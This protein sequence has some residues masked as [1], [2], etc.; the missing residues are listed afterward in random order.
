MEHTK[1]AA[2]IGKVDAEGEAAGE[3]GNA[4]G[5]DAD[6]IVLAFGADAA[7]EIGAVEFTEELGQVGGVVL[8]VAVE[9]GDEGGF[10]GIESGEEGGALAAVDL[11]AD[12]PDVGELG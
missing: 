7:D 10:R 8:E 5:E 4:G 1:E 12:A 3:S 2:C 9:S 6:P 11:V